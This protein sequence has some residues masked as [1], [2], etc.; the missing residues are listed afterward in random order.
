MPRVMKTKCDNVSAHS[1][2]VVIQLDRMAHALEG[3]SDCQNSLE[4]FFQMAGEQHANLGV[5]SK[6]YFLF[7]EALLSMLEY[8]LKSSSGYW[9]RVQKSWN[10]LFEVMF[11]T[12]KRVSKD[13]EHRQGQLMQ[14]K[15]RKDRKEPQTTSPKKSPSLSTVN[16][17]MSEESIREVSSSSHDF[18][19]VSLVSEEDR[20]GVLTERFSKSTRNLL[21]ASPMVRTKQKDE[22]LS[23]ENRPASL[24]NLFASASPVKPMRKQAVN[25][26]KSI[27][28]RNVFVCDTPVTSQN[29]SLEGKTKK[30]TSLRN[31][32]AQIGS[33]EDSSDHSFAPPQ[34][35]HPGS[36]VPPSPRSVASPSAGRSGLTRSHSICRRRDCAVF[37]TVASPGTPGTRRAKKVNSPVEATLRRQLRKQMTKGGV[38]LIM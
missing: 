18:T 4:R 2:A 34:S 9:Q 35:P 27:S 8:F 16:T 3:L 12:M 7:G 13:E 38:D 21:V 14:T 26:S 11:E 30:G 32:V 19:C 33:T 6:H 23:T 29:K 15:R 25:P 37:T 5:Q 20:H 1:R 31:V 17:A 36:S 28:M 22:V 24:R 10:K